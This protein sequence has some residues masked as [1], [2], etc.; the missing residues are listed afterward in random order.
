V[1]KAFDDVLGPKASEH[2]V[3]ITPEV[4]LARYDYRMQKDLRH[5][6]S[7]NSVAAYLNAAAEV[8]GDLDAA[9]KLGP[10]DLSVLLTAADAA[11]RQG[12]AE[13]STARDAEPTVSAAAQARAGT[14]FSQAIDFYERVIKAAPEDP[15]AYEWMGQLFAS[16]GDMD[17]AMMTWRRGVKE[18]QSE[19]LRIPLELALV[20]ALIQQANLADADNVLKQLGEMLA[21]LDP[22]SRLAL[23][24]RVDL[25]TGQMAFL[26]RHYEEAIA[27]VTDLASGSML[28]QG[29]ESTATPKERYDAWLLMGQAHAAL[30]PEASA[31]EIAQRHWDLALAAFEQASLNLPR[32]VAPHWGAAEACKA[33]GRRDAAILNYQ[34]ALDAVSALK[35]PPE[36]LQLAIYNALISMLDESKRTSERELYVDRRKD[37]MAKSPRLTVQGV[38]QAI[39]EGKAVAAVNLA[40]SGVANHPDDPLSQVALGRARQ[41]AKQGEKAAEAYRKAFDMMKDSPALQVVLAGTLFDT[42][43]PGDAAEGEKALRELTPRYSPACLR[44][45]T[46][47]ALHGKSDDA[48]AVA[49]IGVQSHPRD[50]IAHAAMGSAWAAKMDITKNDITKNDIAKAKAEAEF[51]EAVR[52]APDD[53]GPA[54]ALLE[55]YVDTGR[56][57]LAAETLDKLQAKAKAT[58]IE[59]ELFRGDILSR[60]GNRQRAQ[61]AYRKAMALAKD[62]PAVVMRLVEFLLN[63]GDTADDIEA[64]KLLR[65]IKGQYD[66]ARRRL[67]QVLM[68]RGGDAEWEEAQRLLEQSPGDP[69][70]ITD[71]AAEAQLL[72]RRGGGQNLEKAASIC[73]ALIA[74]V[75]R[76]APGLSV[77]LAQI[78]ELQGNLDEARN[79]YR[80]LVEQK[81]LLPNHLA[82]YID[83]LL[84]HGPATEAVERLKQLDD[85]V[86]DDLTALEL[87]ARWLREANR[88]AEIEPLVE[89]RIQKVLAR[90]DKNDTRHE[91]VLAK[92]VGDLYQRLKLYSAAERWY[93]RLQKLGENAYGPLALAIAKQGRIPDA[94]AVCKEAGKSNDSPL[95]ALTVAAILATGPATPDD[96][97]AAEPYLTEAAE[98]YKDQIALQSC[99]ASIYALSDRPAE[100]IK[101]YREI[102]KQQPK[103][104]ATL[105]DLST[106]LAEQPNDDNR[107]EALE[108]IERAIELV[109]PQPN[110]L[111]TKGMALFYDGKPE[112]AEL[113]LQTA[114]QSP[115]PDPRYCFHYAVVCAKLG[116]LD[117]ARKALRQA[118]DSD[119][120]HQL[121]TKK[122]RQLLAGLEKQ[123][124][125]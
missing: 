7:T 65:H 117:R 36:N 48:L 72:M 6:K 75:K 104:V 86:P 113:V 26:R 119:L 35:P 53:L 1:E 18:V 98:K 73:Q 23:Q 46:Y 4:Y 44:L 77:L 59:R 71:R 79:Q 124:S 37:L 24:R 29:E 57:K 21:K 125:Q 30:A 68:L 106:V 110:L 81:N 112:R 102:L 8:R 80:A 69:A 94:V 84:R 56:A 62:D 39:S 19:G 121:L 43:N 61:A 10:D 16:H 88:A 27:L 118:R 2:N 122:D 52:L 9:L 96:L 90:L 41:A 107:K 34:R 91:A 55:F 89:G 32:E 92:A 45:V 115:N 76:P 51:Q 38:N 3:Y 83:F 64:Q 109:G 103:N 105:S 42:G 120:D 28:V 33:A 58:Q 15:R 82:S 17:H 87:R 25:R 70:S 40:E 67:A 47:F 97:A 5:S 100:A 85:I 63:S 95:P 116:D 74:E 99:L 93:L 111:D 14:Y 101:R 11:R 20:D 78:R 123:V 114:A 13:S 60:I 66:P 54:R 50:P 31:P 49:K 22:Q 12:E 108:C